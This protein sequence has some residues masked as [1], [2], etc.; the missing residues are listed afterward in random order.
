MPAAVT[1]PKT[2]TV[3]VA[4]HITGAQL[5]TI[6]AVA[7]ENLT[8]AQVRILEDAINRVSGGG[9]AAAVIGTLLA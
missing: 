2:C 3:T 5:T 6:L 7:P 8:V 9:N 4:P 1:S